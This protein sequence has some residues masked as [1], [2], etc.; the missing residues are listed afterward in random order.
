CMACD[1][2][3][4][5]ECLPQP[6][7]TDVEG[8]CAGVC[9]G[10]GT[11]VQGELTGVATIGDGTTQE[12][13]AL[14]VDDLDNVIVGGTYD[15]TLQLGMVKPPSTVMTTP[16]VAR[17]STNGVP[18]SNYY[19]TDVLGPLQPQDAFSVGATGPGDVVVAG[20]TSD[21]AGLDAWFHV[22]EKW[23]APVKLGG[24]GTQEGLRA[25][26]HP[27]GVV[28]LGRYG[29]SSAV[30]GATTLPRVAD[31]AF[32]AALDDDGVVTAV[33]GLGGSVRIG[34]G[35]IAVDATGDVYVAGAYQGPLESQ[36][37]Q[38]LPPPL[39]L[40]PPG[41]GSFGGGDAGEDPWVSGTGTG[42]F[43]LR[44][45]S[46]LSVSWARTLAGAPDDEKPLPVVAAA[47]SDRVAL[48]W[49]DASAVAR[50]VALSGSEGSPLWSEALPATIAN[51]AG[52]AAGPV[53]AGHIVGPIAFASGE[54]SALGPGETAIV[55][56]YDENGG[57]RWG[58]SIAPGQ[59]RAVAVDTQG[60]VVVGGSYSGVFD[61]GVGTPSSTADVDG[62]RAELNGEGPALWQRS[63]ASREPQRVRTMIPFLGDLLVGGGFAN[64]MSSGNAFLTGGEDGFVARWSQGLAP[65]WLLHVSGSGPQTVTGLAE[66]LTP[67]GDRRIFVAA[68]ANEQ[69]VAG[70]EVVSSAR[71]VTVFSVMDNGSYTGNSAT[72][73]ANADVVCDSNVQMAYI[74]NELV[75]AGHVPALAFE[76]QAFLKRLRFDDLG[77]LEDADL[78]TAQITGLAVTLKEIVVGGFT[79]PQGAGN[80]GFITSYG[81][82]S[83]KPNAEIR[84]AADTV[85]VHAIDEFS[86]AA[87]ISSN[88]TVSI[89]GVQ[90]VPD[91]STTNGF[92]G[93]FTT[94]LDDQD[95]DAIE[96]VS[97]VGLGPMSPRS[98]VV[99]DDG[100]VVIAGELTEPVVWDGQFLDPDG[101]DSFVLKVARDGTRLGFEHLTGNGDAT[102]RALASGNGGEVFAGG[103]FDGSLVVGEVGEIYGSGV[104][105]MLVCVGR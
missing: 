55:A 40:G 104:D 24:P 73:E 35:G 26:G 97:L 49:N 82:V 67:D 44:L 59:A 56:A 16:F 8:G 88:T 68:C 4:S 65:G 79:Q 27:S 66:G 62:F 11:C 103:S 47:G 85:L 39:E 25:L 37:G 83:L 105:G 10:S 30:I 50:L 84:F 41:G 102:L 54:L 15:G 57:Q 89:E 51:L 42:I 90:V 77:E 61:L 23:G 22:P 98:L 32:V 12:V 71:G 74:D 69:V 91:G 95:D 14:A 33:L 1:L 19:T 101:L 70:T 28:V 92:L 96:L 3:T 48:V 13:N 46:D 20:S 86:I 53:L 76:R 93:I 34:P 38:I 100:N 2:G 29:S 94:K 52:D 18:D 75:V 81:R 43:V 72:I 99:D 80:E 64:A 78:G 17:F 9:N 6:V 60:H 58:R 36:S 45:A 87:V 21:G 5:G 63:L 31:G 7:G